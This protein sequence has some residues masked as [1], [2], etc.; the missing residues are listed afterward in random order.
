MSCLNER[1]DVSF[2]SDED[3][4][5]HLI[6]LEQCGRLS[7]ENCS[8]NDRNWKQMHLCCV[9]SNSMHQ[10]GIF[11]GITNLYNHF[12]NI[13]FA[14]LNILY[15]EYGCSLREYVFSFRFII[16]WYKEYVITNYFFYPIDNLVGQ[17]GQRIQSEKL[18]PWDFLLLT[19]SEDV[20]AVK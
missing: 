14:M 3:T 13:I 6:S 7:R 18:Y 16:Q 10:Q 8:M 1:I 12:Y 15:F 17:I 4:S 2:I 19:V 20:V 9:S 11:W 5:I